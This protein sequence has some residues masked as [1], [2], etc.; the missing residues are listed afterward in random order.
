MANIITIPEGAIIEDIDLYI[1]KQTN[2]QMI[3]VRQ[4]DSGM[5]YIRA[6][7]WDNGDLYPMLATDIICLTA[8]K[9]DRNPLFNQAGI[10]TEGRIIY[11]MTEQTTSAYGVFI[12]EFRIYNTKEVN[13]ETVNTLKS[14]YDF[15][16]NVAKS[17][18]QDTEIISTPEF[19]A[20]TDT[21]ASVGDLVADVSNAIENSNVAT[22]N[23]INATNNANTKAMLADEKAILADEKATQANNAAILANEKAG[24]ADTATS[25]ANI[26]TTNANTATTNAINATSNANTA[27]TNAQNA[28]DYA[29][30]VATTL[31]N[32]TL[33]IFKPAVTT[34]TDLSIAY[35]MP[36]NGWTVTVT[37]EVVSY[38]YNG[39][40]W[41]NLGVIS[42]VDTA[43]DTT[44]GIVKGGGNINIGIDGTLNVPSIGD[45]NQLETESKELVGA[46][47]EINAKPSVSTA[48]D[49]TYGESNVKIALDNHSSQLAEKPNKAYMSANIKDYGAIGD[50][51]SHP[52]S[53]KFNSLDELKIV[54]PLAQSLDD[55]IDLLALEKALSKHSDVYIPYGTYRFNREVSIGV[56][57]RVFGAG[58]RTTM[59][60]FDGGGVFLSVDAHEMY[61]EDMTIG[62][63]FTV[64]EKGTTNTATAIKYRSKI[65]THLV[66][67]YIVG[68][69]T[70][71]DFGTN[72]YVNR[73]YSCRIQ[74]CNTGILGNSE[75]NNIIIF[76]CNISH[77]KTGVFAGGGR[78]IAISNSVI[79]GNEIAITKTNRGDVVI[80]DNYLELNSQGNIVIGWGTSAVDMALIE[81]NSFYT[82]GDGEPM[83][84]YHTQAT[85]KIIVRHNNFEHGGLNEGVTIPCLVPTHDTAVKPVFMHNRL[86][87]GYVV[88]VAPDRI[89][90]D[91][92]YLNGNHVKYV[93][94]YTQIKDAL[95]ETDCTIRFSFVNNGVI[96]LPRFSNMWDSWKTFKIFCVG[97][98]VE[99]EKM[100]FD[101]TNH[102]II[103]ESKIV[104]NQIYSIIFNRVTADGKDEVIVV[105]G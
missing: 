34:Y 104:R 10:D 48:E 70:G 24:L 60:I 95:T 91:T 15:K 12:A 4:Y 97:N 38:R 44:L 71:I 62:G 40:E 81:G 29:N 65:N 28:A 6:S 11:E 66:N 58:R 47:N 8:T 14:T 49:V 22:A 98:V 32:E 51:D 18:V 26:A 101:T 80:R 13:G 5:R 57:K 64:G 52:A 92:Y 88:G 42:S 72:S 31:D 59:L 23:A 67:L 94:S 16:I 41:I 86:A 2:L 61:L 63:D 56:N 96:E 82:S 21:M 105:K 103:G 20:L 55:E 17:N 54:Y 79:E 1:D 78:N 69:D 37:D 76:G 68:F 46:I 25:N 73:V 27:T 33:K 87:E 39:T 9:P 36:E 84:K 74:N 93:D 77:N 102:D 75:F 19:N 30:D 83:I 35:P 45:I 43:T 3:N 99:G 85:N 100:T 50:W 90:A 53:E 89:N 7:V